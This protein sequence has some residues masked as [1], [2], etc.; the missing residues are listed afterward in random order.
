[1]FGAVRV[2]RMLVSGVEIEPGDQSV[3]NRAGGKAHHEVSLVV[4]NI[5]LSLPGTKL[6]IN[7]RC[8]CWRN[9]EG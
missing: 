7:H 6:A 5:I 9:A 4:P 3:L 8:H 2:L 1:M